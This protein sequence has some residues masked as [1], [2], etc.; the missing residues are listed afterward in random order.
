MKTIFK[1][2]IPDD[3]QIEIMCKFIQIFD[4]FI[5]S[6]IYQN[7]PPNQEIVIEYF[8]LMF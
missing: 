3:Q 4:G 1:I 8:K 2:H 6:E 7:S 5:Q